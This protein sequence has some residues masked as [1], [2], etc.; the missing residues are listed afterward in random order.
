MG[1]TRKSKSL[2]AYG[3]FGEIRDL[4]ARTAFTQLRY[5]PLILVG[6]LAGNVSDVYSASAS[7]FL[8]VIQPRGSLDLWHGS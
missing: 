2:R 4:I 7:F 6:T 5:S 1:L 8:R 3:T